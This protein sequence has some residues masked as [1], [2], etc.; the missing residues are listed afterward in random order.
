MGIDD[1]FARGSRGWPERQGPV[2]A[3]SGYREECALGLGH[4]L[5]LL[6]EVA[7]DRAAMEQRIQTHGAV[8]KH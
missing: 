2:L 8:G 4:H 5:D 1:D 3:P 6:R 7:R